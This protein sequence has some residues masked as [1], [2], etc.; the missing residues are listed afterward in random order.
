MRRTRC[1]TTRSKKGW[2]ALQTWDPDGGRGALLAFR[3]DSADSDAADR[4]A[5]RARRPSFDLLEAPRRRARGHR[6]L[7]GAAARHRRH[8]ARPRRAGAADRAKDQG[9]AERSVGHEGERDPA[10]G[11]LRAAAAAGRRARR[12][13]GGRGRGGLELA[14]RRVGRP[15]RARRHVDRRRTASTRASHS[16][17]RAPSYGIQ[18]RLSARALVVEGPDGERV[19]IVKN[20]LYIPQDLLYRRAAQ[21][22]EAGDSGITREQPDD[23]GH[24]QP[25]VALLLVAVVGRVGLPGRVRHPL[26]RV[27]RAA[28]G[29]RRS[30]RR[31]RTCEP[32]RVGAARR[33]VRQDRAPLVRARGRR[34]RHAGRLPERRRR[35]RPD[36]SSA[37]TTSRTR[38]SPKPLANLVNFGL[39][40]EFLDGNDLISADYVGAARADGRPRR[41]AALT[42]FTQGAVGTARARA[43]PR[44]TRSTSGSSSRTASTPRPSAARG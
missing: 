39:H 25:L 21:I 19:A 6:D 26:L 32:V 4:P 10:C 31:P 28:H 16:T 2:T 43:Q 17:R 33:A 23:G 30:R 41:P 20:D 5:Q 40:P 35:P 27:L 12:R 3:Q 13:E 18:S 34:R 11:V 14:R 44:T 8:A 15:V 38:R 7:G 24:A 1:S 9:Q 22:L 37:S 42:I 36:R 29:R